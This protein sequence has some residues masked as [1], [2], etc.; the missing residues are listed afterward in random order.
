[1]QHDVILNTIRAG[2][3]DQ[4]EDWAWSSYPAVAGLEKSPEWLDK[5]KNIEKSELQ[6]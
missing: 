2:M 5:L 6:N 4:L 1:M 3:V